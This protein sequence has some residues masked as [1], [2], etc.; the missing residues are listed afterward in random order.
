V[1]RPAT[2]H[3]PGR[4]FAIEMCKTSM[5]DYYPLAAACSVRIFE[6]QGVEGRFNEFRSRHE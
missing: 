4:S 6:R 3:R 1:R 5:G 2:E